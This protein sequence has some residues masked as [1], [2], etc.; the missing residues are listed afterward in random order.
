MGS[1]KI[2]PISAPRMPTISAGFQVNLPLLENLP[3]H[4]PSREGMSLRIDKAMT[5]FPEPLS[6]AMPRI[7]PGLTAKDTLLTAVDH[8]PA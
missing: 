4:N 5:V 1:W 2:M 8:P 6:P 7:S 3:G